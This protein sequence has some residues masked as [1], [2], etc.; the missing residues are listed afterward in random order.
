ML[1]DKLLVKELPRLVKSNPML[2]MQFAY[3]LT[4]TN[5]GSFFTQHL[6]SWHTYPI[7]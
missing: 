3:F 1:T 6:V 4:K 5:L 7:I 2:D